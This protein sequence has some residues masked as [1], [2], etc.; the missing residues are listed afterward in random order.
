MQWTQFW[1]ECIT[2]SSF[3]YL[4]GNCLGWKNARPLCLSKGYSLSSQN[5]SSL[6]FIQ[7]L[8]CKPYSFLF[9][10]CWIHSVNVNSWKKESIMWIN[11]EITRV[12]LWLVFCTWL[13]CSG[14]TGVDLCSNLKLTAC[15]IL[16]MWGVELREKLLAIVYTWAMTFFLV[17]YCGRLWLSCF[18]ACETRQNHSTKAIQA[19]VN[20]FVCMHWQERGQMHLEGTQSWRGHGDAVQVLM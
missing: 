11:P 10:G 5:S 2:Q 6:L 14:K 9:T 18:H 15:E 20:W 8:I 13:S 3:T 16:H 17:P 12:E 1:C 7:P 19:R 4:R